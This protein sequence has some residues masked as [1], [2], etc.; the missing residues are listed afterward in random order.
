M[1]IAVLRRGALGDLICTA[2]L[3]SHLLEK[4]PKGEIFLFI[5]K[6]SS[7]LF[8]WLFSSRVRPVLIGEGNKYF[9]LLK[10]ALLA[11]KTFDMA[12]SAK[13][14]PMKLNDFFLKV[15]KA[16]ITMAVTHN[17]G[18]SHPRSPTHTG[19][20]AL[21]C[22]KIFDPTIEEIPS[23]LLPKLQRVPP[24]S[25]PLP[26]PI[27]FFSLANRRPPSLL[28]WRTFAE[29]AN[30]LPVS[31]LINSDVPTPIALSLQNALRVPSQV[32]ITPH[33]SDLLQALAGVDFVLS[34]DGGLCHIASALQKPLV[35]LYA[36]TPLDLWHPLGF[37]KC[38]FDHESVNR[39]HPDKIFVA[40][41][42]IIE[43][44]Y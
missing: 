25:I 31:V 4:Y 41:R 7:A 26:K 43:I 3:I 17:Q 35:A 10:E 21:R 5:Q 39:I 38:L 9:Q 23:R 33:L 18:F 28:D 32:L 12:I 13:T 19:H 36:C 2:P 16:P 27:L 24:K 42:E 37:A 22:L 44:I 30:R 1:K 8:P 14:T 20:Q 11:R 29:V 15:L 40:L 34:G 6:K